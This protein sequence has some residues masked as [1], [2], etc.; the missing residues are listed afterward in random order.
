MRDRIGPGDVIPATDAPSRDARYGL[1]M[2]GTDTGVAGRP[3]DLDSV[4]VR[5]LDP[6]QLVAVDA[7]VAVVYTLLLALSAS[8]PAPG[9]SPAWTAGAPGAVTVAV[10]ALVGLPPAARRLAPVPVLSVV[11]A[12][13][14]AGH[15]LHVVR[16]PFLAAAFVLYLV[17]QR[18]HRPA[19]V[20]LTALV[21]TCGVMAA[22][23]MVVGVPQPMIDVVGP[24]LTGAVALIA[25][26]ALGRTV[27]AR[28]RYAARYAEQVAERAVLAERLRIAREMHDVVTHSLG[29]IAVKA[30]VANHVADG[31]P[32]EAR[33]AL[34]VIEATSREA[35]TEMRRMLGVLREDASRPGPAADLAVLAGRARAAGIRL[36]LELAG[37][38]GPPDLSRLPGPV[39]LTV[40]R[41]V[42]E[43]LTNV[44]AHAPG[45]RCAVRV[46]VVRDGSAAA[47]VQVSVTDDG[48]PTDG[49]EAAD[50][51]PAAGATAAG[52]TAAA[53]GGRGL[54]GMRERVTALGGS[55]SAGPVPGRG[56][57]VR[58]VIPLPAPGGEDR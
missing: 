1:G 18:T 53:A 46:D 20:S 2:G 37:D 15:A 51:G 8:S 25:A 3:G 44:I 17:V 29:I 31:R 26:A 57:A 58:A 33:D 54:A 50:D 11:L 55:L 49:G 38:D 28:R 23:V 43:A 48:G 13:T 30:A 56:F 42:Q 32:Q 41:V 7:A 39:G 10:V 12:A 4:V 16:E 27:Q 14:V 6:H 47:E 36:D 45:A 35:L 34:Q 52:A 5:R 19:R 21:V 40:H 24:F 22:A 9:R